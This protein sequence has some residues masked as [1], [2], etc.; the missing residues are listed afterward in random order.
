MV[1]E[2]NEKIYFDQNVIATMGQKYGFLIK[3]S[4]K[5][6]NIHRVFLPYF[7]KSD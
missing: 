7:L 4:S 5:I 2:N 3:K 6:E 1:S